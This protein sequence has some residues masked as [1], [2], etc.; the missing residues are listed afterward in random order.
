MCT[1]IRPANGHRKFRPNGKDGCHKGDDAYELG[2]ATSPHQRRCWVDILV[3]SRALRIH[4]DADFREDAAFDLA[5]SACV[6]WGTLLQ[7]AEKRE[8]QGSTDLIGEN[9]H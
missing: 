9:D 5:S 6:A 3:E 4:G 8:N 2:R 1:V 7:Y